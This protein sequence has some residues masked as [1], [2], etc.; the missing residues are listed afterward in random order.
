MKY[1][2]PDPK[3]DEK[4]REMEEVKSLHIFLDRGSSLWE[5]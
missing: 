4:Q 2:I 3:L 5:I 1:N